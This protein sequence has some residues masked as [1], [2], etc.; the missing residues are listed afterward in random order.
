MHG[1]IIM[2][3]KY[4]EI[5]RE[6]F[7][8]EKAG[9][10]LSEFPRKEFFIKWISEKIKNSIKSILL[11]GC[12]NLTEWQLCEKY[13]KQEKI[14]AIDICKYYQRIIEMDMHNITFP[15]NSFDLIIMSHSLEHCFSPYQVFQQLGRVIMDGG[16]IA[17][18]CPINYR[19]TKY[20][21]FDF[22]GS[23]KL[24]DM[25]R[26]EMDSKIIACEDLKVKTDGNFCWTD[27]LKLIVQVTK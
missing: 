21:R 16:Y 6:R 7:T 3:D 2:S 26:I 12:S 8:Q 10:V 25:M 19:P 5:Q 18:E 1:V 27:N 14:T 9:K 24:A 13:I 4:I 17:C 22:V 15:D 11:I 23:R 20:D